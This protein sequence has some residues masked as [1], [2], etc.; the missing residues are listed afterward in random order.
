MYAGGVKDSGFVEQLISDLV[1]E[2]KH[3][4]SLHSLAEAWYNHHSLYNDDGDQVIQNIYCST[5]N[6][7]D[8]VVN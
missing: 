1:E 8:E 6:S 7:S 5:Y 2:L 3:N 4:N